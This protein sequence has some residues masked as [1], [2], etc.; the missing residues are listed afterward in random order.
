LLLASACC[1]PASAA[2]NA[3]MACSQ[4]RAASNAE[5]KRGADGERAALGQ[6]A[7]NLAATLEPGPCY[8]LVPRC[9]PALSLR[10]CERCTGQVV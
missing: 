6:L 7:A 2:H 10:L 5:L 3:L 1:M 9:A 8:Y 4:V